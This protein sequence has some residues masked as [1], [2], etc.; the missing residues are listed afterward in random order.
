VH[1]PVEQQNRAFLS[2]VT[3]WASSLSP[4]QVS[5]ERTLCFVIFGTFG[6]VPDI[7][8]NSFCDVLMN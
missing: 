4:W 8:G 5:L 2:G 6:G 3:R 7:P 1:N